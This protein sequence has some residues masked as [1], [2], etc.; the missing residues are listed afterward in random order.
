LSSFVGTS[1]GVGAIF[2]K[3]QKKKEEIRVDKVKTMS[4]PKSRIE[5]KK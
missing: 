2:Q 1:V 5:K 4:K 3:K